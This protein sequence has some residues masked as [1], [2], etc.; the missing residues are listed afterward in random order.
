MAVKSGLPA[1]KRLTGAAG[2]GS[3]LHQSLHDARLRQRHTLRQ[4]PKVPGFEISCLYRPM[5]AVGG[6][7]YEFVPTPDGRVGM[8]IGDASGHGVESCM[9]M[10]VTKKMV[11]FFGRNGLNPRE[12]LCL[13]NREIQEDVMVGVFI[14]AGYV[15]L[16]PEQREVTYARAGHPPPILYN[17]KRDPQVTMLNSN[18]I[19]LGLGGGNRFD[20]TVEE[21][22][23]QLQDGDLL[24]LYTDGLVELTAPDGSEIGEA[25]LA[26]LV[27]KYYD[28]PIDDL[29]GQ[30]WYQAEKLFQ[31]TGQPDD[32]TMV[33][34]K[35]L[36]QA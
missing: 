15:V 29:V 25:G 10:A 31:K 14:S 6:D 22:T 24:I 16:D 17:P 28:R 7:F 9:L 4:P 2:N 27:K 21:K 13:V 23:I 3:G 34:L 19:A 1:Q 36:P 8:G 35:V 30:I 20:R 33:A 12:C 5:E 26:E 11:S 32:I 18:G